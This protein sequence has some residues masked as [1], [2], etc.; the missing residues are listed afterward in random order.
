MNKH[1]NSERDPV[2]GYLENPRELLYFDMDGVLADAEARMKEWSNKLDIPVDVL[3]EKKFY[4]TPGFYLDLP[5]VKDAV[6]SFEIL[7]K[8]YEVYILSAPCWENPS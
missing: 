7:S 5:P 8:K 4:H 3:F 1:G 6:E 2:Y